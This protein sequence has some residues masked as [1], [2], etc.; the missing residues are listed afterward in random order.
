VTTHAAGPS[1]A[2]ATR[3]VTW[4]PVRFDVPSVWTVNDTHETHSYPMGAL[5]DGPFIGTL[6][7][8][9]M[10]WSNGDGSGG[11]ARSHGILDARPTEGVVA[12]INAGE[13]IGTKRGGGIDG[14]GD[15]GPGTDGVCP[16][17]GVTFHAFRLV[18]SSEGTFRV[19][20]DGCAYGTRTPSYLTT[21]GQVATSVRAA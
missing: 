3:T 15:P 13:V 2:P 4:G 11:C 8:G 20:V 21:L 18:R 7:T 5:L 9:P 1:P 6:R 16:A 10:C 12:W 19:V 17:G 14:S